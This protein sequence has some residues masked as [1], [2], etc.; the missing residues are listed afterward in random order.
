MY[1]LWH[2]QQKLNTILSDS[3]ALEN[4]AKKQKVFVKIFL[5][6]TNPVGHFCC[7]KFNLLYIIVP[8]WSNIP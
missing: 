1:P 2:T 7:I 4:M 5:L 8:M 3:F 6:Y